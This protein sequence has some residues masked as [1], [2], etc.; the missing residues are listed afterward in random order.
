MFVVQCT[1]LRADNAEK[2][3]LALLALLGGLANGFWNPL[4]YLCRMSYTALFGH[5]QRQGAAKPSALPLFKRFGN[6]LIA[7]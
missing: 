1:A 4:L 2:I 6:A 5:Q 3:I 7:T